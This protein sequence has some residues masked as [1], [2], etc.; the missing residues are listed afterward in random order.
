MV[1]QSGSCGKSEGRGVW[2]VGEFVS[3][4]TC[5]AQDTPIAWEE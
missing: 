2:E 4:Q 1:R 3:G 5:L